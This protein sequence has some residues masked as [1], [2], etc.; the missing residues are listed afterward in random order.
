MNL[1]HTERPKTLEDC[2]GMDHLK[3]DMR[4]FVKTG[5]PPNMLFV[6]PPGIGKNTFAYCFATLYFGREIS[7]DTEDGDHDYKEINCS[8]FTGVDTVREIISDFLSTKA[9]TIRDGVRL[10]KI[11]FLNEFEKLSNV[12]KGALKVEIEK[13]EKNVITIFATNYENAIKEDALASRLCTYRFKR[14]THDDLVEWFI[15]TAKKHNV[16]F[17][18]LGLV[19]DIVNNYKGDMRAMLVDC[20]EALRGYEESEDGKIWIDKQDLPKIYEESTENYA[21]QVL[22][23]STP[24]KTWVRLWKQDYF[25]NRKFLEDFMILMNGKYSRIFAKIDSRLRRG[26]N[27][28][29]QMMALFDMIGDGK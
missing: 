21:K 4:S 10:K 7:L 26:C 13:A 15:K 11:L 17:K 6:G 3:R 19:N 23:S 27:E 22:Q 14:A 25:D 18:N 20:L 28:M 5:N 29:I 1:D 9:N 24:K 2:V 8:L 16:W 12:A